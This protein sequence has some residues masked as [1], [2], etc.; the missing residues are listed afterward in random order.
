MNDFDEF[1]AI[2]DALDDRETDRIL[3]HHVI[4]VDTRLELY[5][6]LSESFLGGHRWSDKI[7]IAKC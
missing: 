6:P 1:D 4:F 3:P 5:A 7:A 2:L